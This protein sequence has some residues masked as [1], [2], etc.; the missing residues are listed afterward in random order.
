MPVG[1]MRQEFVASLTWSVIQLRDPGLKLRVLHLWNHFS[2]SR[3]SV[4]FAQNFAGA[5][6]DGGVVGAAF[7]TL[8]ET[9]EL[10]GIAATNL[11]HHGPGAKAG[12]SADV[13]VESR[14]EDGAEHGRGG[15][16]ETPEGAPCF[17]EAPAGGEE[18]V[19]S[20]AGNGDEPGDMGRGDGVV[21]PHIAPAHADGIS[22]R[23]R[24]QEQ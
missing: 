8:G 5:F 14:A 4:R 10:N 24:Y 7:D 19:V 16:G 21:S 3:T 13:L 20:G 17:S 18:S 11:E 15:A 23:A 2:A 1:G 12:G 6:N 9:G 22:R